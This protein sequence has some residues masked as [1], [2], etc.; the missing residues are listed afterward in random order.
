MPIRE[1]CPFAGVQSKEVFDISFK[2]PRM[3]DFIKQYYKNRVK[4]DLLPER[5]TI[6][7]N[8][9]LGF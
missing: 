6:L 4:R 5:Y 1:Y 9:E 8:E 3:E 7:T 2:D